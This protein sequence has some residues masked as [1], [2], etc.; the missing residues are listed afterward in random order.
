MTN[1]V[2]LWWC[3]TRADLLVPRYF[4]RVG[5]NVWSQLGSVVVSRLVAVDRQNINMFD[6]SPTLHDSAS[7]L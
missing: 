7:G 3:S 5:S 4:S 2:H 1:C 6:I